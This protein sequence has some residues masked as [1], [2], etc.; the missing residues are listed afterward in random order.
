[1]SE[2]EQAVKNLNKA[3][4]N[5]SVEI[6]TED[7]NEYEYLSHEFDDE[8]L[9]EQQEAKEFA[10]KLNTVGKPVFND[11]KDMIF[12]YAEDEILEQVYKV[13]VKV[14]ELEVEAIYTDNEDMVYRR[15]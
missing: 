3:I 1:M 5:T 7:N 10:S 8:I 15:K 12:Y 9:F 13:W 14:P 4:Q 11:E 6:V 2:V